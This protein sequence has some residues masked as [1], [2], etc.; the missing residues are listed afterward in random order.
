MS[1]KI[2]TMCWVM[3]VVAA[4]LGSTQ[5]QEAEQTRFVLKLNDDL[6][7]NLRNFGTLS[8][9]V[10]QKFQQR[11]SM[12]ELQYMG[13]DGNPA[14]TADDV[15]IELKDGVANIA[16]TESM[17]AQVKSGPLRISVP[18]NKRSFDKISLNYVAS[19]SEPTPA[20]STPLQPML[21]AAGEPMDTFYI[22]M[23]R[24][25]VMSGGIDGLEDIKLK[26]RFGDI[27]L[28]V[29]QIA[30]IKF[31]VD[32]KDSAVVVLNNGDTVTGIPGLT[33]I[34]LKTDWGV[35][36][37]DPKFIDVLTTTPN[38]KFRQANTDFGLRWELRTGDTF[39]P[40]PT[41]AGQ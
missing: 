35:A 18:E 26:T 32:N 36:E 3:L 33:A 14:Q 28:P 5:A 25:E 30:G 2:P 12:V 15:A 19:S 4:F 27:V 29:K 39:A 6:A 24:S 31:H 21:N 20:A 38:A 1:N 8:S 13:Q 7:T 34:S 37:I 41:G 10:D 11:I 23:S 40:G 9:T 22:R 17:I 16:I